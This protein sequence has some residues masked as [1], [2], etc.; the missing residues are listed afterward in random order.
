[1]SDKTMTPLKTLLAEVDAAGTWEIAGELN[2]DVIAAIEDAEQIIASQAAEIE[3]LKAKLA[4]TADGVAVGPND[5]VWRVVNGF[6]DEMIVDHMTVSDTSS[7][8][9]SHHVFFGTCYSTEAAARQ[10]TEQKGDGE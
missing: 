6:I 9:C 7:C 10:A 5:T 3:V 4:L 2:R 8:P 1:M